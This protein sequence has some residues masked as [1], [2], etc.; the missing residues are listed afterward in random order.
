MKNITYLFGAGAS[1]FACPIWKEQGEKMI[2]ISS[3]FEIYKLL[4]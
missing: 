2:A 4:A 3:N 1:Y